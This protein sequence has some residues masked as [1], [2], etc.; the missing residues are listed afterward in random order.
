M[1]KTRD[2]ATVLAC[3]CAALL[4]AQFVGSRATRDALYLAYMPVEKLPAVVMASAVASM[5]LAFVWSRVVARIAPAPLLAAVLVA[6]SALLIVDWLL[7]PS[8]QRVAAVMVYVQVTVLGPLVGSGLWLVASE[9]FD[10]RSARTAF[11]RMVSA[12]AAG[13]LAGGLITERAAAAWGPLRVLGLLAGAAVVAAY[14]MHR[15]GAVPTTAPSPEPRTSG[16]RSGVGVLAG[17]AILRSL[18]DAG[19]ILL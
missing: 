13:G 19:E 6:G 1:A 12:G 5:L 3:W 15:L 11:A 8:L 18:A 2:R 17:A 4:M 9:R 7:F 16:T 14:A 10:P